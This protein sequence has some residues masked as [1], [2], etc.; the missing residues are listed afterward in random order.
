MW[1]MMSQTQATDAR[2]RLCVTM[3]V[4]VERATHVDINAGWYVDWLLVGT[5]LIIHIIA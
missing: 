1:W 3:C 2:V 5:R 4:H